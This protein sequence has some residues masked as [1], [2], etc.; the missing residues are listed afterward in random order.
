MVDYTELHDLYSSF[1]HSEN[2]RTPDDLRELI[3]L[4][5]QKFR[6]VDRTTVPSEQ[7]K[8]LLEIED[9]VQEYMD[10]SEIYEEVTRN[11]ASTI[12]DY[13]ALLYGVTDEEKKLPPTE[14]GIAGEYM[15][16]QVHRLS[17]LRRPDNELHMLFVELIGRWIDELD[18]VEQIR[19]Y[20]LKNA[21]KEALDLWGYQYGIYRNDEEED[22]ELRQRIINKILE[23]FTV[24]YVL[25]NGVTFF[26]CVND[27]Q[28]QLTSH[29]T[30][31]T[32]DYLC[33]A[34]IPLE[35]YFDKTY[36]CWRDIIW[37]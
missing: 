8:Y 10:K 4:M 20:D 36:I 14:Y 11:T 17:E 22:E 32:N 31:L 27:P 26:T 13:N 29:N 3:Q 23:L 15:L 2:E 16:E 5:Q 37:L 28:T 30:Y 1:V 12:P 18:V 35:E 25:A 21:V 34:P 6:L 33:Y 7:N 24:P 19:Q 9:L